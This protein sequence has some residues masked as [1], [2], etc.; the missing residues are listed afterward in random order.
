LRRLRPSRRAPRIDRVAP[1]LLIGPALYGEREFGKLRELGVTHIVDLRAER[2]DDPAHIEVLGARWLNVTI[3]DRD[4]P[5]AAQLD[6]V[7]GWLAAS[8][9]REG[10]TYLHCEGGWGRTPTVAIALLMRE[11]M[12][13]T[14]AYA[15]V[16][17]VRPECAVT[18]PQ[19]LWL[20][21]LA[22]RVEEAGR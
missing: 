11:G 14:E 15:H 19:R 16:M 17:A 5:T 10:S 6:E 8:G 20:E 9:A 7:A 3:P 18:E 13:L 22:G 21:S 4:A 12:S 2:A 1:W